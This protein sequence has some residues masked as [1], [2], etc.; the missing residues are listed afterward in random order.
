MVKLAKQKKLKSYCYIFN[1]E[2]SKKIKKIS[3]RADIIIANNVF[4]HADNPKNFLK[5][6]KNLLKK[7]GKFIFEQPYFLKTLSSKKVSIDDSIITISYS[8]SKLIASLF[9]IF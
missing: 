1:F 8:F 7:D 6:I 2:N 5:G 4:N 3:G 9:D